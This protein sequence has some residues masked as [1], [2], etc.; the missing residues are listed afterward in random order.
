MPKLKFIPFLAPLALLAACGGGGGGGSRPEPTP[1]PP[2]PPP[3]G[4]SSNLDD[5]EYRNSSYAVAANALAAYEQGHTGRG[6]KIAIIDSGIDGESH[7]FAG[8]IDPAST[9]LTDDSGHGSS[10]ARI[11]AGARNGAGTQ[12]VAYDATIL[13]IDTLTCFQF[14]C[15]HRLSDIAGAIDYSVANGADVINL[16]MVGPNSSADVAVAVERATQA[17]V[18]V[19]I[20][21]GNSGAAD[22][23]GFALQNIPGQP[24]AAFIIAGAY[25]GTTLNSSRAGM[26]AA[27]FLAAQAGTTSASTPVISGAVALLAAAFPNL[28][29]AQIVEILLASADDRG[30]PGVDQIW[31]HGTLNIERAFEPSG[32]TAFAGTSTKLS[33]APIGEGSTAMGDFNRRPGPRGVVLDRYSRAYTVDLAKTVAT[34]PQ[35][36]PLHQSAG[37]LT[38]RAAKLNGAGMDMSFTYAEGIRPEDRATHAAGHGPPGSSERGRSNP[39]MLASI[40][41]SSGTRLAFATGFG[42][43]ALRGE[44][45]DVRSPSFIAADGV[46][47]QYGLR[48]SNLSSI[49][50]RQDIGKNS[51]IATGEV[52]RTRDGLGIRQSYS[53]TTLSV[54]RRIGAAKVSVGGARLIEGETVLG[55]RFADVIAATGSASFFADLEGSLDLGSGWSLTGAYRRGWTSVRGGPSFLDGGALT[56]DAFSLDLAGS[57]LASPGDSFGIRVGQPLRVRSGG[58]LLTLPTGFDH[59]TGRTDFGDR[60]MSL[61][62]IG[63]ELDVEASYARRFLGGALSLN[64]YVR[65]DA[66]NIAE[67]NDAGLLVRFSRVR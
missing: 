29:G 54:E 35:A 41:S 25:S 3:P 43:A 62:P 34:G 28:T 49:G 64:A 42:S 40:Q 5:A 30:A 44:L 39:A 50:V 4:P 66:G 21:A 14:D 53:M 36:M 56:S 26:G 23:D 59:A 48:A 15:F 13:S 24:G 31:G 57:G 12:G 52:G 47:G 45:T 33:S 27:W 19:V 55:G 16:S 6:A 38:A 22:P 18:V 51:I 8:R 9:G 2:P 10:V 20:A 11:A 60:T 67:R 61:V 46:S 7:E 65:R 32:A 37:G 1:P 17:G 63:R 58:L